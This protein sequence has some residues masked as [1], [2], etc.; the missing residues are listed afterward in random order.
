MIIF[1]VSFLYCNAVF[2]RND[3]GS[4][5]FPPT[6]VWETMGQ[7]AVRHLVH[8]AVL[9]API[10]APSGTADPFSVDEVVAAWTPAPLYV[11]DA[12]LRETGL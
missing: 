2:L 6:T 11:C 9:V 4:P 12:M 7:I 8:T 5:G 3:S 10:V 1:K